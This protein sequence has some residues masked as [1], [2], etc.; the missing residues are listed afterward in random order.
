MLLIG[1]NATIY[2]GARSEQHFGERF[3]GIDAVKY[4]HYDALSDFDFSFNP[5][6]IIHGAGL[7]SPDLYTSMPVETL[8]SNL[9]GVQVLLKY[10]KAEI[11]VDCFMFHQVKYMVKKDRKAFCR[12]NIWRSR[13]R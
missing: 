10:L 8:L 3:G 2:V 7:A 5:D 12:G 9:N 13:Y 6:Y 4:V 11:P 1:C